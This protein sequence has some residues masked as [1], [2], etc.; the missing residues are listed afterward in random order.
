MRTDDAR[1]VG[2][3]DYQWLTR[4]LDRQDVQAVWHAFELRTDAEFTPRSNQPLEVLAQGLTLEVSGDADGALDRYRSLQTHRSPIIRLMGAELIAWMPTAGEREIR[5]ARKRLEDVD[6]SNLHRFMHLCKL[7]TF[8]LD[9]GLLELGYELWQEAFATVGRKT[10]GARRMAEL[11]FNVF[12]APLPGDVLESKGGR[13]RLLDASWTFRELSSIQSSLTKDRVSNWARTAGSWSWRFGGGPSARLSALDL[14]ATWAGLPWRLPDIRAELSANL[15]ASE[16]ETDQQH[17][18]A[19]AQW[20]LGGKGNNRSVA[21]AVEARIGEGGVIRILEELLKYGRRFN[22]QTGTIEVATALWHLIGPASVPDLLRRFT[23][24]KV[25]RDREDAA[26]L[27]AR[28]AMLAPEAWAE[29][30]A[31]L[32]QPDQDDIATNFDGSIE[33]AESVLAVLAEPVRRLAHLPDRRSYELAVLV[34]GV[35][36]AV[37]SETTASVVEGLSEADSILL[38][39]DHPSLVDSGVLEAAVEHEIAQSLS[40]LA[41]ARAGTVHG[42]SISPFSLL[43]LAVSCEIPATLQ[44]RCVAVLLAVSLDDSAPTAYRYD[45]LRGLALPLE[46]PVVASAAS[47][48]LETDIQQASPFSMLRPVGRDL[49]RA[50]ICRVLA[51]VRETHQIVAEQLTALIRS[52]DAEARRVAVLAAAASIPVLPEGP[53]KDSVRLSLFAAL[54]DPDRVVL[55]SGLHA[56]EV[57]ELP[58]PAVQSVAERLGE[59]YRSEGAAVRAAVVRFLIVHRSTEEID[60]YGLLASATTDRS[61]LVRSVASSAMI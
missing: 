27:W 18:F 53:S 5:S 56:L 33:L 24:A 29:M 21:R 34:N 26:V 43:G 35:H 39:T 3:W 54:W 19:V 7:L 6:Q 22:R 52:Q 48:L 14:Q 1:A 25:G 46:H 50:L 4:N 61:W 32:S 13:S 58:A 40:A 12:G 30:F 23:P 42:Y 41:Q 45:A 17:E 55:R 11:G 2:I 9:S 37:E 47:A 15:L 49:F 38:A 28:L 36:G 60:S 10:A 51:P 8:A 31:Q 59:L 57:V 16:G 44:E 20:V